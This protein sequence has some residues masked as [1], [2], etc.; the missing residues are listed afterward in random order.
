[1]PQAGAKCSVTWRCKA[2]THVCASAG[3]TRPLSLMIETRIVATSP[4]LGAP[5]RECG[6]AR[7][8]LCRYHR[9]LQRAQAFDFDAHA[10][11]RLHEHR[12]PAREADAGWR[13]R[14]YD[15]ARLKREHL[16]Q[17]RNQI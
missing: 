14:R 13:T 4:P 1:M 8:P 16:R 17:K 2:A 11:A 5:L 15:I 3:A 9:I 12:R 6:F 10:I 7:A